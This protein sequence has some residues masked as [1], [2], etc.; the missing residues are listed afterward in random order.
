MELI[1]AH[2]VIHSGSIINSGARRRVMTAEAKE[3][4][5]VLRA[6]ERME[7]PLNAGQVDLLSACCRAAVEQ[8]VWL[9]IQPPLVE[10]QQ[11]LESWKHDVAAAP[12]Q[13]ARDGGANGAPPAGPVESLYVANDSDQT[14]S[15]S[16]LVG[17][18]PLS[19]AAEEIAEAAADLP[20]PPAARRDRRAK[21]V[22]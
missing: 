12:L 10:G 19:A 17:Y 14:V 21:A 9:S 16:L 15:V 8:D 4:E 11:D 22:A 2:G 18:V 3:Q 7:I 20:P 13:V 5:C 1:L 6:G